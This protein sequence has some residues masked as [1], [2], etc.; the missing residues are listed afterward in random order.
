VGIGACANTGT[1]LCGTGAPDLAVRASTACALGAG[2]TVQCWGN[3]AN[4]ALG[5]GTTVTSASPVAVRGLRGV[6]AVAV[7]FNH[8]CALLADTTVRCWGRNSSGQLGDGTTSQRTTPVA[9]AG[10]TGATSVVANGYFTCA[11]LVDGTARCWGLNTNGQL[12]DG[13]VTRQLTPVP[14][15]GLAGVTQ[16]AAGASHA[17]ALLTDGTAQCWGLNSNGQLGDG[18]VVQ[19]LVPGPV[20]GLSGAT[21]LAAGAAFTCALGAGG[22][23]TC[24]GLNSS[25]QLGDGTTTRRLVPVAVTGLTGATQLAAG[26]AH[27]CATQVDGAARC[28]GSNVYGQ[29]GDGTITRRLTPTVITGLSGAVRLAAGDRSTC[30]LIAGGAVQCWGDNASG[31]L[32]D[33]GNVAHPTPGAVVGLDAGTACSAV[34][35]APAVEVCDGVDNDCNG[36][37]DDIAPTACSPGACAS[38]GHQACGAGPDFPTICVADVL[39]AVGYRCRAAVAGGCDVA[40]VCDGVSAQCPTD[41]VQGAGT[42]C[43]ASGGVCDTAEVCTGVS[44]TCPVDA[45]QAAGTVCRPA[46]AGVCDVAETCTGAA[47]TCPTDRFQ[48]ATTVCRPAAGPCDVAETCRGNS[49][50]CPADTL[51]SATYVC[52]AAVVGG[53]DVAET[54]TG[55]AVACPGDA[56][57]LAGTTC[58]AAVAGGCD[59]AEVCDGAANACPV[60]E[61]R[62]A[63]TSCRAA[64]GVCDVGEA[65]NGVASTCPVDAFQPVTVVCRVAVGDCDAA[66]TCTGASRSCPANVRRPAGAI[67]RAAVGPCDVA[68]VCTGA[69][70]ACPTAVVATAGTVCRAA[71]GTC[72][73][74]EVCNGAVTSCPADLTA[75]DHTA[76]DDGDLCTQA[77]ACS[78]GACVSGDRLNCD[79][80]N[81]C[82]ADACGATCLHTPIAGCGATILPPPNPPI[83][84]A[85]ATQ[86]SSGVA[87]IDPADVVAPGAFSASGL[88]LPAGEIRGFVAGWEFAPAGALSSPVV[89]RVPLGGSPGALYAVV[90]RVGTGWQVESVARVTADG[91]HAVA[92]LARLGQHALVQMP[93]CDSPTGAYSTPGA[94]VGDPQRWAPNSPVVSSESGGT[95]A[96]LTQ[97]VFI[98]VGSYDIMVEEG[99]RSADED[100]IRMS[101]NGSWLAYVREGIRRY[102]VSTL[103]PGD[104]YLGFTTVALPEGPEGP[105]QYEGLAMSW[106]GRRMVFIAR[107]PE[108]DRSDL[109]LWEGGTAVRPL[110]STDG[111]EGSLAINGSVRE[112]AL[113]ANGRWMSFVTDATDVLPSFSEAGGVYLRDLQTGETTLVA[114]AGSVR[115]AGASVSRSGRFVAW[116]APPEGDVDNNHL[117]VWDRTTGTRAE[118]NRDADGTTRWVDQWSMS[119]D[120]TRFVFA[121]NDW[122]NVEVGVRTRWLGAASSTPLYTGR[123]SPLFGEVTGERPVITGSGGYVFSSEG[124]SSNTPARVV[125]QHLFPV[126]AIPGSAR[127]VA[128]DRWEYEPMRVEWGGFSPFNAHAAF[129]WEY[130][131]GFAT[132]VPMTGDAGD[133]EVSPRLPLGRHPVLTVQNFDGGDGVGVCFAREDF[134]VSRGRVQ[135]VSR[136]EN[137]S[138]PFQLSTGS[139]YVIPSPTLQ[140]DSGGTVYFERLDRRDG[141]TPRESIAGM[142]HLGSVVPSASAMNPSGRRYYA[143]VAAGTAGTPTLID[144]LIDLTHRT[145]TIAHVEPASAAFASFR[146]SARLSHDGN[147]AMLSFVDARFGNHI[148]ALEGADSAVDALLPELFLDDPTRALAGDGAVPFG[149]GRRALFQQRIIREGIPIGQFLRYE[150]REWNRDTGGDAVVLSW[151]E[152]P[153]TPMTVDCAERW[154]DAVQV[155]VGSGR[156]I[157]FC[158]DTPEGFGA[159]PSVVCRGAAGA[160][161]LYDRDDNVLRQLSG[162]CAD[163]PDSPPRFILNDTTLVYVDP[164]E[165][166]H[167]NL[168]VYDVQHHVARV[169]V[170]NISGPI[171]DLHV[172]LGGTHAIFTTL[173]ES[174]VESHGLTWPSSGGS[175]DFSATVIVPLQDEYLGEVVPEAP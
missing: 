68:E 21:A 8:A 119:N 75:A 14:V 167:S 142:T 91:T 93:G 111:R 19:R 123:V 169:V 5:D 2:G 41:V 48:P 78:A 150:L 103:H 42:L 10:L 32:G 155:A 124:G 163:D 134:Q 77:D 40:E 82:T 88:G 148:Y 29:L 73:V 3:N 4:G 58:R 63:G 47:K 138:K 59:V 37:V 143:R 106:D 50:A 126:E 61:V 46:V 70:T 144:Y 133:V 16:I 23:A 9:V 114:P 151:P 96:W 107:H 83:D 153:Y 128:G 65:C 130:A 81:A 157:T 89:V 38:R 162:S 121:T 100:E 33:G 39:R 27:A 116:L 44:N 135:L 24:W 74:A 34:P 45:V 109:F 11:L 28:W 85:A 15:V 13:T 154:A 129:V 127:A 35:G 152:R 80:G 94:L 84:T 171:R 92:S 76:C 26:A 86:E 113:S 140:H 99:P 105:W 51:R 55:S 156:W 7:G 112:V 102:N 101:G 22:S 43:R 20:T 165:N 30:A 64:N 132:P 110:T 158:G 97:G 71:T 31:Q 137:F 136:G 131:T 168:V 52:R 1:V 56:V 139:R 120:G 69:S 17:C 25:G 6:T 146:R 36:V 62:P 53:C 166:L 79:D 118:V 72:D 172:S 117:R 145:A 149:N 125:R 66:E 18:T 49:S 122:E 164:Q 54:C 98:H 173:S 141:S 87:L 160:R 90:G 161:W 95:W 60:N 57:R 67:C 159:A 170:S 115:S 108:T 175:P 104:D 174:Y 12:G 147:V